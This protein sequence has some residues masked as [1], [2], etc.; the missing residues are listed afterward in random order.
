M[1]LELLKKEIN[2]LVDEKTTPEVAEKI[3]KLNAIVENLEKENNESIAK[4]ED[5]RKKYV[6]LV[7]DYPF[8]P[9]KEKKEEDSPLSLEECASQ[10]LKLRKEK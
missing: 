8:T 1:D 9:S 7:K 10:V 5:L 2:G 3:G 4:F 6:N